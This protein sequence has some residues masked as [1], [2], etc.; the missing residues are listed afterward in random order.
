MITMLAGAILLKGSSAIHHL[1]LE[2][3]EITGYIQDEV[4]PTMQEL[5]IISILL[6]ILVT[7]LMVGSLITLLLGV[8]MIIMSPVILSTLFVLGCLRLMRNKEEVPISRCPDHNY[9]IV[10]TNGRTER[11]RVDNEKKFGKTGGRVRYPFVK[12]VLYKSSDDC[13]VMAAFFPSFVQGRYVE[14]LDSGTAVCETL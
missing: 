9:C 4:V 2:W 8:P 7:P 10:R 12:P 6:L 1:I 11:Y 13:P 3:R 14:Q 5:S